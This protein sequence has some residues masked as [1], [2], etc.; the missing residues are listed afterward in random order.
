[1]GP[2]APS[3]KMFHCFAPELARFGRTLRAV[4]TQS[5]L[6]DIVKRSRTVYQCKYGAKVENTFLP[7]TALVML[8]EV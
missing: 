7:R 5:T 4:L 6:T 2:L 1:M 3:G 8:S